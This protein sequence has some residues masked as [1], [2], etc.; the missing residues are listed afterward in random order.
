MGKILVGRKLGSA[1]DSVAVPGVAA[2][3]TQTDGTQKAIARGGTKGATTPADVTTTAEGANHQ[4]LDVQAYHGGAAI[5]PRDVSDRAGRLLGHVVVDSAPSG[6]PPTTGVDGQKL[7]AV[8][9]T[10]VAL[11]ATATPLTTGVII[12][13]LAA[14]VGDVRVGFSVSDPRFELQPGQAASA[15]IDDL[16]KV[17]VNGTAGDG[18]CFVGS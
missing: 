4:A 2:A 9:N 3:A 6:S 14:N 18:V 12:Q 15:A 17:Y 5:D 10:P 7:I 11:A 13:A 8:T 1:T 16:A